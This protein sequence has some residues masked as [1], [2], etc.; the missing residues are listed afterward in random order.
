[1]TPAGDRA[2]DRAPALA[3]VGALAPVLSDATTP[4]AIRTAC[5]TAKA[6][7]LDGLER[8]LSVCAP[9]AGQPRP[10]ELS[11]ALERVRRLAARAVETDALEPFREAD[12]ELAGLADEVSALQWSPSGSAATGEARSVVTLSLAD[13][14]D[15]LPLADDAARDLA[16]R[17]RLLPP[18]AAALRAA[19]D[20]LTSGS[21]RPLALR[22]EDSVLEVSCE[23]IDFDAL[24]PATEV[25][26]AVGANLGPGPGPV[27]SWMVRVPLHTGRDVFLMLVHGGV[28]IAIP[29]HAVLRLH[30]AAT[31]EMAESGSLGGWPLLK[32]PLS[33]GPR[34]AAEVPLVLV[35]HGRKRGWLLADRLVWRL[36]AEPVALMERTP[37]PGLTSVVE[38]EDGDHYWLADPAWLLAPVEAPS[39]VKPVPSVA[40]A[41]EPHAERK[42]A[43]P[44]RQPAPEPP[45]E[46]E[47]VPPAPEP[48]PVM[49]VG[50][51]APPP[52]TARPTPPPQLSARP[53]PPAPARTPPAPPRTPPRLRLLTADD[54]ERIE[55]G[56]S[57]APVSR[58]PA[59]PGAVAPARRPV[60]NALVAED[61]ITARIFLARLLARLGFEVSTVDTAAALRT[62][63]EHGAW[64]LACVDVELPDEAGEV[65]LAGLVARHGG[66]TPFLALVRDA[67][68]RAAARRAGIERMLRKPFD[69]KELEQ[70]LG[71]LGFAPRVP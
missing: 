14:L 58:A 25:L 71:R 22:T 44:P 37:S 9:H 67:E 20:W 11:P 24:T 59:A 45:P 26:A 70:V 43:P 28:P 30:M 51:P 46:M 39:L 33:G 40:P 62:E 68:D 4:N 53:M 65:F 23:R 69:Q 61:S 60:R 35:A 17:G 1:M 3:L 13:A 49:E 21:G 8:L 47:A 6:L 27:G 10:D 63:L 5:E 12:R 42:S 36:H 16:R 2:D 29:W 19:L 31:A 52:V 57:E 55:A 18:V 48:P 15:E 66:R 41:P 56:A 32:G 34:Q 7:G 54:V 38:T 50:P 64:S